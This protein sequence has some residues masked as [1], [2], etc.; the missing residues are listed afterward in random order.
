M[1]RV[2]IWMGGTVVAAG[3]SVGLYAQNDGHAGHDHG[4]ESATAKKVTLTGELIDTACFVASEGDAKGRDHAEC[5]TK[6]L[7]S[8]VP[9]GI[10]PQGAKNPTA[11]RFLLTNPVPLAPHAGKTIKVEGVL[12]DAMHA[13]D[14]QKVWVQDGAAWKE[15]QLQD[16]HH[17]MGGGESGKPADGH[18]KD[19]HD[20]HSGHTH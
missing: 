1:R 14:T 12:H 18:K 16:E 8:G 15:I 4:K 9:A 11:L 3:L 5:G 7:A 20:D 13:I 2:A 6:C 10:L 19:A 17:Q